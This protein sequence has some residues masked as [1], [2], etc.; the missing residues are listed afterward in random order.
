MTVNY[1]FFTL[2]SVLY[3]VMGGYIEES[4]LHETCGDDYRRYQIEV[5]MFVPRWDS[6]H[7]RR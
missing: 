4:R 3:F 7:P 2:L 6:L 1:A 5:P